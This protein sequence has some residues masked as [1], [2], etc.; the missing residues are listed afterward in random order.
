MSEES[1]TPDL[2][3]LVRQSTEAANTRDFE[4][5]VPF[6]APDAAWD[7]SPTGLGT[8]NGRAAIRGFFEDWIGAYDKFEIEPRR[9]STSATEL[10]SPWF[11]RTGAWLAAPVE[12][13]CPTQ[14]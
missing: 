10:R 8:Y 9:S 13:S 12:F 7:M 2:V 1:T 4:L 6:F 3:E 11:S 14:R 5:M